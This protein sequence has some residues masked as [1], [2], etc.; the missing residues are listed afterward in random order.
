MIPGLFSL[1]T[2]RLCTAAAGRFSRRKAQHSFAPSIN[3]KIMK[4]FDLFKHA[5]LATVIT[6]LT[7]FSSF[8]Q[9]TARKPTITV[10]NID[11]KG[12]P[13]DP[14]QMGNITRIELEKLDTFDV[15]D[16]Y[17][18]AYVIDKNKLNITNCYG[19]LCLLEIGSTIKT[20]FMLTG[21][22]E[23]YGQTL[24]VTFRLIDVAKGSIE[25]TTVM[26]FLDLP[27]ELQAMAQITLHNMFG[28]RNDEV[29][30]TRLTKKFDYENAIN[31]PE[32]SRL[33]LQGP[34]FGYVY[35]FGSQS[36]ILQRSPKEGGFGAYP[37]MF[38]FGY[39]FEKQYLNEGNYQALF[40]FIPLI[41]GIDQQLVIPSI[42]IL[43]GFRNNLN[44]WE[45]AIGP[46]VGIATFSYVGYYEGHYYT[47]NELK[48]KGIE[49]VSTQKQIDSRGE[50]GL[51]SALVLAVGKTF[52]SG[53]MN[54][55]VNL[56]ATIPTH[57]GFKVGLS[58]GYNSK[59]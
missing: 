46:S 31:N 52:K 30:V 14:Q 48:K 7:C 1:Y 27:L 45:L 23:L 40:E 51:T 25:K 12:V 22:A 15:M 4:R 41:T 43:N 6:M 3:K 17:D 32:S 49:G 8:A 59:K 34:R 11:T 39:Q 56:Y 16:R 20:D 13:L 36:T 37:A 55:P 24:V 5:L 9:S 44:G 42:T 33:N 29:L 57:E 26:E 10:L 50:V 38:Q 19:K 58:I 18:V 53:K 28:R 2:E 54:I 47:E 21:S 35:T